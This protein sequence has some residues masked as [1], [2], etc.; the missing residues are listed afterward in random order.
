MLLIPGASIM[1]QETLNDAKYDNI[2]NNDLK[3]QKGERYKQDTKYR[4]HLTCWVMHIV[5]LWLFLVIIL[6]Y[7]CGFNLCWLSD[8]AITALL[9]TTTANILGLAYIILK[10]M[11]QTNK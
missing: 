8:W 5:S 9:G 3:Q 4:K 6:V 2:D 1:P 7:F 11:F 10:G